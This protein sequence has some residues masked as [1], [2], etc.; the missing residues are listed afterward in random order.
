[1]LEESLR[2]SCAEEDWYRGGAVGWEGHAHLTR[3]TTCLGVG[4]GG[5]EL[6]NMERNYGN[7]GENKP[8]D[9]SPERE[10]VIANSHF[11]SQ[12][13]KNKNG[14]KHYNDF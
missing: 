6:R 10:T 2:P 14:I 9:C 7:R 3:C 12:S 13:G 4:T 5:S 1:M 8:Q 11:L